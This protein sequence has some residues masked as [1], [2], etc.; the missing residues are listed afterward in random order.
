MNDSDF[1]YLILAAIFSAIVTYMMLRGFLP[2]CYECGNRKNCSCLRNFKNDVLCGS[3]KCP[4]KGD[5]ENVK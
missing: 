3:P 4:M 1:V 2:D 5:K